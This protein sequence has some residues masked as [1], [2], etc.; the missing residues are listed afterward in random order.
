MI[1]Q[2]GCLMLEAG[3]KCDVEKATTTQRYRTDQVNVIWRS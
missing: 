3:L 1:A 2:A